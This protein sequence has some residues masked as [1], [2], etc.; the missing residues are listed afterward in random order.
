MRERGAPVVVKASGLA[1]GKGAV[2]CDSGGGRAGDGLGHA[3]SNG[4]FGEAGRVVVVEEL[5]E[6]EELSLFAVTDGVAGAS[7]APLRAGPQAGGGGGHRTQHGR[8]GRLQPQSRSPR[9]CRGPRSRDE[10][11]LL[12]TLRALAAQRLPVPGT[13]LRG[14]HAHA[15]R[16]PKVVEFNCRFGDPRDPGRC[17]RMMETSLLELLVEVAEG[18]SLAGRAPRFRSRRR[19]DHRARVGGLPGRVLAGAGRDRRFPP[20]LSAEH[21]DVLLFHAGTA[22]RGWR[23][24]S[25]PAG[26]CMA[27][28]GARGPTLAE[29]AA[30]SRSAAEAIA[31]PGETFSRG[32]R[33]ARA[34]P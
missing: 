9:R 11:I 28:T 18:G 14:P 5:L 26:G 16:S 1:A 10:R 32:H 8:D 2:V 31:V 7:P 15:G 34:G 27:V 20:G 30:Q 13:P 25:P 3:T 22:R 12:P 24:W 4:A 6:G 33:L 21:P 17:C 19:G 29:A 23:G